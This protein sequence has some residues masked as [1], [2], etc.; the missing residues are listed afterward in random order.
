MPGSTARAC[1][2]SSSVR[3][4]AASTAIERR[5]PPLA[6][7]SADAA[8][9]VLSRLFRLPRRSTAELLLVRHAEPESTA[10]EGNQLP[11]IP[12]SVTGRAQ[13]LLLAL[14]LQLAPV[15]GI[16]TSTA[17][18]AVETATVI[19]AARDL[20]VERVP[21][22]REIEFDAR[23]R[24][25]TGDLRYDQLVSRFLDNP[26]WEAFPGAEPGR[27]FRHRAIQAMER[28]AA[29]HPRRQVVVVTHA[30]VINAYLSMVLDIP[31]DFFFLPAPASI[32][33][34][35]VRD[36]HYAVQSLNDIAHLLKQAEG[37]KPKG[38]AG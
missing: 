14:R 21:D 7:A 1:S 8:A 38:A 30:G 25:S 37:A 6:S 35:R 28:I 32:S 29:A 20:G 17:R 27:H 19:A 10:G 13:A 26:R 34:V 11:G 18:P 15:E 12:L 31:R 2:S 22:L 23:D 4:W 24:I 33:T 16:Y 3:S 5:H 36:G 9:V